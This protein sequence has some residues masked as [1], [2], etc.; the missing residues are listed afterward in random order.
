[1]HAYH[2]RFIDRERELYSIGWGYRMAMAT[3][4]ADRKGES[5]YVFKSFDDLFDYDAYV[6]EAKGETSERVVKQEQKINIRKLI[7]KA[8]YGKGETNG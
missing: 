8:N 5:E 1:M 7:N 3:K 2:L 6:K 4:K